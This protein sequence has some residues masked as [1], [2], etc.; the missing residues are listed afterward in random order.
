MT[1]LPQPA[2]DTAVDDLMWFPK[3]AEARNLSPRLVRRWCEDRTIR[4]Y[5]V[6]RRVHVRLS[7]LDAH[8]SSLARE[9]VGS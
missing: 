1:R 7:D 6:G 9:P 4:S 2:D 3:A 8:L 5:L